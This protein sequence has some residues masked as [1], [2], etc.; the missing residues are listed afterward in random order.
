M[1]ISSIIIV[2][3]IAAIGGFWIL[4]MVHA[5]LH[6]CLISLR[7]F[8]VIMGILLGSVSAAYFWQLSDSMH[9]SRVKDQTE[10][11]P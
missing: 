10:A 6:W 3:V 5:H 8:A 1:S 11:T 4:C 9:A 7:V 2:T